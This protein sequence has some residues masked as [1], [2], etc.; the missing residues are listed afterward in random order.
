MFSFC[1]FC[2]SIKVIHTHIHTYKL[3][4]FW[5]VFGVYVCVQKQRKSSS[6]MAMTDALTWIKSVCSSRR[7][8]RRRDKRNAKTKAKQARQT[9]QRQKQWQSAAKLLNYAALLLWLRLRLSILYS[10]TPTLFLA[11]CRRDALSLLLSAIVCVSTMK[12]KRK[13][14]NGKLRLARQKFLFLSEIMSTWDRKAYV[15][16]R[17]TSTH[18]CV[19]VCVGVGVLIVSFIYN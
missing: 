4:C 17:R 18:T 3:I 14:N 5:H 15:G 2:Q 8:A 11:L 9:R 16:K 10:P 1:N 6:L 19:C 13:R 12:M 7:K